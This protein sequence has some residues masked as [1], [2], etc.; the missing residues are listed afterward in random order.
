MRLIDQ[1]GRETGVKPSGSLYSDS[2]SASGGPA[3]TYI[4]MMRHN[5]EALT[6]A[7]KR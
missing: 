4:A 6:T 1:I 7:M 5:T 2:L 3:P